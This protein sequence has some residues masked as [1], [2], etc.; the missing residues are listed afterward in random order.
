VAKP[1]INTGERNDAM[2]AGPARQPHIPEPVAALAGEQ[3]LRPV[4]ENELG[5][6]TFEIGSGVDRYFVKWA[7]AAS[8]I[9]LDAE[10]ARM[11]WASV[12]TPVPRVLD[13][14]ADDTGR[15]MSISPV[16]GDS[17]V[18]DRWRR[19]PATA[20]KAIGKGLRALHDALPV[21]TCPFS[22]SNED[23][24]ADARARASAGLVDPQRWH[25]VH[26][27]LSLQQALDVLGDAPPI[28]R[29]V[30]CHGDACAPN[31]IL[32]A[33]GH[34]SGHVDLGALGVADR[35]A[36][37]AVATWS[38]QWNFGR[39]WESRLLASYGVQS[40]PVRTRFYRL[41]WDLGP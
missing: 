7:P 35:W 37:L 24:V 5:G 25:P 4:W 12:F 17:A 22:W 11:S 2:P 16:P 28:D 41:L 14:G 23:R 19:D 30:V 13:Q 40:D 3:P 1:L 32:T 38:T 27:S 18:A 39:G 15:W 33:A 29:A 31:T 26:R 21:D 6:L 34:W 10:A 36:D 9:D 20:V 8:G